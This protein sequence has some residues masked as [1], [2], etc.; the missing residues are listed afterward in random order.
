M[1]KL[2]QLVKLQEIDN[3]LLELD[4]LKGDLPLQVRKLTSRT[5]QLDKSIIIVKAR[6]KEIAVSIQRLQT[7]ELERKTKTDKLQEQLYLVKTNREYDAFMAEIDHLKSEIDIEE[8]QELELLEEKER[9]EEQLKLEKLQIVEF[10]NELNKQEKKLKKTIAGT[11]KEFEELTEIRETIVPGIDTRDLAVYDRIRKARDGVAVVP[12]Q[13]GACSGCFAHLTSKTIMEAR[14]GQRL[15]TCSVCR[16]FL[17]W[18]E[19]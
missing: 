18:L 15:L 17:Y 8:L 13:N 4:Q 9:L 3:Q 14:S 12:I 16:R 11:E 2:F 5:D 7:L 10:S 19:N 1:A 6:L